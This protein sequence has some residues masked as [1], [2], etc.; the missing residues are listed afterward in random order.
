MKSKLGV[1]IIRKGTHKLVLCISVFIIVIS[2]MLMLLTN[3]NTVI[4]NIG[5]SL[6]SAGITTLLVICVQWLHHRA[7]TA[8]KIAYYMDRLMNC[9]D[10]IYFAS[11]DSQRQQ[12][13]IVMKLFAEKPPDQL[14]HLFIDEY[15]LSSRCKTIFSLYSKY[16]SRVKSIQDIIDPRVFGWSDNMVIQEILPKIKK[17]L[18]KNLD[19][20]KRLQKLICHELSDHTIGFNYSIKLDD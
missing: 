5:I 10:G 19:C 13:D 2:L 12:I 9:Y 6:L 1:I 8:F 3:A 4:N 20:I 18:K 14:V 7:T 16:H 17:E 15:G 11:I